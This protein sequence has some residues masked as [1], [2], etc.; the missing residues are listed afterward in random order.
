MSGLTM[1]TSGIIF[2]LIAI[3]DRG[4]LKRFHTVAV[5]VSKRHYKGR[6][7]LEPWFGYHYIQEGFIIGFMDNNK[8]IS[9]CCVEKGLY[10]VLGVGESISV[11]IGTSRIVKSQ[12]ICS[13]KKEEI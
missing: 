3:I 12:I 8:N 10:D 2:V 4:W 13:I 11:E 1:F 7:V 6:Y 5:V 9:S